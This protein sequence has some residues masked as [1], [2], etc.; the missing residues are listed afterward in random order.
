MTIIEI[1]ETILKASINNRIINATNILGISEDLWYL[2]QSNIEDQMYQIQRMLANKL[3]VYSRWGNQYI[4]D[5]IQ[6]IQELYKDKEQKKESNKERVEDEE[7][8]LIKPYEVSEF[9]SLTTK[10]SFIDNKVDNLMK[11]MKV[12]HSLI[13]MR[14]FRPPPHY[15]SLQSKGEQDSDFW[16][17]VVTAL[18]NNKHNTVISW[19]G[20]LI[21][22]FQRG[23]PHEPYFI[24][25]DNWGQVII[26]PNKKM[27]ATYMVEE[28]KVLIWFMSLWMLKIGY[29]YNQCL[30]D[31]T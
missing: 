13:Q 20:Y 9:T 17:E 2:I 27:V 22:M 18:V 26:G 16:K 31:A 29:C 11:Y 12:I 5:N 23:P 7:V 19:N 4:N 1:E 30:I 6:E 8:I 25:I 3:D 21:T 24:A 15:Q 14:L 10:S 28:L